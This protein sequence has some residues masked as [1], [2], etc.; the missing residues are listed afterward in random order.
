MQLKGV[1]RSEIK[2]EVDLL[3]ANIG[4]SSKRKTAGEKLSG[5]MMRKLTVGIALCGPA[6]VT[7]LYRH[8]DIQTHIHTDT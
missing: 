8:T 6:E 1:P 4:L 7:L 5:G 2:V 3:L